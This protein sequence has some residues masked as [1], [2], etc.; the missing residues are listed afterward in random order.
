[1]THDDEITSGELDGLL[2]EAKTLSVAR[3][4]GD[5]RVRLYVAV[6]PETLHELEQRAAAEGT[7]LNAVAADALRAGARAA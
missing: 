6:D 7:D 2:D 3:S 5:T 1:M 4:T